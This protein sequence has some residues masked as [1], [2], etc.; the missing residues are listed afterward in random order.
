MHGCVSQ[1]LDRGVAQELY[2][3][4]INVEFTARLYINGMMSLKDQDIFPLE[5]FSMHVLMDNYL[6]YH[7]RGICTT[8]GLEKLT[9]LLTT[10]H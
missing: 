5:N 7:L 9:Q 4:N 2:R 10:N 1:N 6:E 8:K 3:K